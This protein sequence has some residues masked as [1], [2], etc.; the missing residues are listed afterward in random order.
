MDYEIMVLDSSLYATRVIKQSSI[1]GD[2]IDF[3]LD[4]PFEGYGRI[5]VLLSDYGLHKMWGLA[6]P[7]DVWNGWEAI[8]HET[9]ILST[10]TIFQ[11]K[12]SD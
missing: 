8:P 3:I 6:D 2:T 9:V 10:L 7:D 5:R 1:D 11:I 12:E 4:P